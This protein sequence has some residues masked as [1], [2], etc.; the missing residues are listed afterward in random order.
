MCGIN[1]IFRYGV[2]TPKIDIEQIIATR[3]SMYNRGPDGAGLWLSDCG[4]VGFGHRRLAIIEL[5]E[6]GAQ[7]MH[8]A[9]GHLSITFNGEIYNHNE[10]RRNL[11]SKGFS[12]R[13]HSD[14]EVL[15]HLYRDIG[16]EMVNQLR[17]MFAFALWDNRNRKLI[18][19]RDP[20]GIKPVYYSNINGVFRFA[21]QVKALVAGSG[22]D[23]SINPA[24]LIS[25]LLWG[26]VSEPLTLY[27]NINAL[28]AGHVLEIDYLGRQS[29]YQYWNI[30]TVIN[31]SYS[32]ASAIPADIAKEL[33]KAAIRDSVKAHMVADVPVGS[34]L[35]AGLDSATITGL[36]QELVPEPVSAITL[37]FEE[38]SGR[39][40]DEAPVATEIASILGVKHQV[41]TSS[42]SHVETEL[43][44]FLD[45]MDQPTIDGINTWLVSKAAKSNGLKVV[46]SGL[47]GDEMLGGYNTFEAI[48]EIINKL[49]PYN[50]NPTINNLFFYIH[51]FIAKSFKGLNPNNSD[52]LNMASNITSAYQLQKGLFMPWELPNIID[53]DLLK[54]GLSQLT[55]INIFESVD[56]I[57]SDFGKIVALESKKY[58]RNQLLRDTDWIGMAHSLEIRVP[59]VDHILLFNLV[60][61]AATGKLGN[62]KEI[63]PQSLTAK[64]DDRIVNR[65]KTG[66]TIPIWRWLNQSP[67]FSSWK[68]NK[69]LTNK[70][71]IPNKRW[72]YCVLEHFPGAS[73][74]LK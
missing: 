1:G 23:C 34:F 22:I 18:I 4:S 67:A 21:S 37:A 30:N 53:R 9:D 41:V 17:G 54:I 29:I 46:L 52:C 42:M 25:F 74:Y 2:E 55:K 71:I 11:E 20:Y 45:A 39:S 47:G 3:D 6:L 64:L 57:Q 5:S 40:L 36:A 26:S 7:P 50:S 27:E 31:T 32:A 15:L 28:P 49:S 44:M 13:S 72:A 62:K 56:D 14:T 60:G 38:F 73:N 68:R 66:F 8:T 12:F 51:A 59:L 35:S 10:L 58:M 61:S 69:Y 33:A 19:A 65:P 43:A 16:I 63:L 48:P 70:N 24:A